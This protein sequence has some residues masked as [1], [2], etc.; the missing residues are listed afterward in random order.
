MYDEA[1]IA[2]EQALK[3]NP[4]MVLAQNNLK[5]AIR[6]VK[7]GTLK[8]FT[9]KE[10]DYISNNYYKF[11]D[12]EK[13]IAAANEVLRKDPNNAVAYNNLCTSYNRLGAYEKAIEMCNKAVKIA[14]NFQM[15]K[16][17][18]KWAEQKLNSLQK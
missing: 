8:D 1:K 12:Q 5:V 9:L 2:C 6:G 11:G 15:A 17:N 10:Y 13:S 3:V 14:P 7:R 18:L 16:N 4:N